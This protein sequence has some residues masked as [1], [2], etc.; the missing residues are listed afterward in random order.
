MRDMQASLRDHSMAMLRV[1]AELNGI[2]LTTN[3]REVASEQLAMALREPDALK[4]ALERCSPQ[5]QAAW[6]GLAA[7]GGRMK[8]LSFARR[9]GSPRPVGPGRL[10]RDMVWREPAN[11]AE[12]LWYRGLLFRSFADLGDGLIEY[13][14]LPS[15]VPAALFQTAALRAVE[16]LPAPPAAGQAPTQLQRAFNSLAVDTCLL[17]ALLAESPLRLDGEG[18]W[19]P[20]DETR[21][22]DALLIADPVRFAFLITLAQ[23]QGWLVEEQGRLTVKNE[24]VGEWLRGSAWDQRSAFFNAWRNSATWNDLRR[25]PSLRAE[26]EWR[27]EPLI[28]RRALLAALGRLEPGAWYATADIVAWIKANDP[29]FQRPDGSYTGWYLRDMATGRYLSGFE[30]WDEVEGRLIYFMISEPLFWLSAIEMGVSHE[31]HRAMFRLSPAGAAWLANQPPPELPRPA[32]L[33]VQEDFTITAP[34]TVPLL[35]RF[36]L[37]RFTEPKNETPEPGQPTRHRVTRRSLSRART[38]GL[39]ADKIL[40][41]LRQASA[42]P[43]PAKVELGLQRWEQHGGTVRITRG[44][45]LRVE[46]AGVMAGLRADPVIGP[47]LGELISAQAVMVSLASLPRLTAA[48]NELGYAA[49]LD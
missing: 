16:P 18:T 49:K 47:L 6:Q 13:F 41:F 3:V 46:D 44:A 25:V 28:A 20:A 29:D 31:G 43:V 36:R 15:D 4:E 35:D 39:K 48:L 45:V 26:G 12:E 42:G 22:R 23:D 27:N 34:L 10:E 32:R 11:P 17:L 14:Y 7:A 21:L 30:S 38:M 24:A 33:Q 5:A 8:V 19:R 9:F 2:E 37:L 40:Q 1:I